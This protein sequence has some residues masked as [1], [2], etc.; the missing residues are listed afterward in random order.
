MLRGVL[1]RY[2]GSAVR[3]RHLREFTSRSRLTYGHTQRSCVVR[4]ARPRAS[5]VAELRNVL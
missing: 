2:D 3:W 5:R 1:L 4:A